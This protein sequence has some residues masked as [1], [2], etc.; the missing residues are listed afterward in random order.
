MLASSKFHTDTGKE[1]RAK[2][3]HQLLWKTMQRN[4]DLRKHIK[5]DG[6][7]HRLNHPSDQ[8]RVSKYRLEDF[9]LRQAE[10][11]QRKVIRLKWDK[12][13]RTNSA[14]GRVSIL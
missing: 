5:K 10:L 7:Q 12:F 2:K 8:E 3:K 4:R 13:M 6:K 1:D 9:Y 14:I 11:S